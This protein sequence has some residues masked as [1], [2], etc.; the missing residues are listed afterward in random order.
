[1]IG[2]SLRPMLFRQVRRRRPGVAAVVRAE[3][4]VAAEIDRAR[5]VRRQD[6]RRAPVEA[7]VRAGRRRRHDVAARRAAT[8]TAPAARPAGAAPAAAGSRRRARGAAASTGWPRS[9]RTDAD[10]FARCADRRDWCAVLRFR[11]DDRPVARIVRGIEA[12]AAADAN[13]SEFTMPVAL[14]ARSGRTSSRCPAARRR[15]STA[16]ACRR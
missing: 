15:R 5:V 7:E 9:A 16:S 11:V 12:V 14:R 13:Q 6:E 1:M 8:R 2:R 10:P 3:Q 4:P